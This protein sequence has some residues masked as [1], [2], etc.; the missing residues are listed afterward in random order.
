MRSIVY[1]FIIVGSGISGNI[2]AYLL[3]KK[4]YKTIVLEK[5]LNRSEKVCG[6]GISYKALQLLQGIG[7]DVSELKQFDHKDIIGCQQFFGNEVYEKIYKEENLSM[8]IQR[9]IFDEFLL[10][11]AIAAGAEIAYNKAVHDINV[12]NEYCF[13]HGYTGVNY[14]VAAG[15]RGL[16]S[17]S[18][19]GQ[20]F[21]I[22]ALIYGE[23]SFSDNMFY[24][25]FLGEDDSQYTWLFPIGDNLWN[26]GLWQRKPNNN[27]KDKFHIW[28]KKYLI[29][30]FTHGYDYRMK[31]RGEF[32]GHIDQTKDGIHGVGDFAGKCNYRNG[33]GI[34]GAIQSAIN[35]VENLSK[36]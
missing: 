7:I 8:G 6:G 17:T 30:H 29:P 4:G 32:L 10:K 27:I 36:H 5:Q 21:A 26:V 2:C 1:D 33:G 35:F 14:V 34:I 3:Q 20:S 23:A 22:S 15:A 31:L 25:W 19:Q 24:Y 13:I 18:I 28:M 12:Q 11:K 16:H 9:R